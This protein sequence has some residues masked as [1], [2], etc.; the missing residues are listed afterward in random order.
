[1]ST[2]LQ[3]VCFFI[4]W[5]L[6]FDKITD[7]AGS[8]NFILVA[9]LSFFAAGLGTSDASAAAPRATILTA[10]VCVTRVELACFLLY[11]VLRRGKDDRFDAIRGNFFSF[12]FFWLFQ[13]V[14]AWGV[15]LPV[16]FVNADAAPE[17]ALGPRD[18]AGIAMWAA[19][20][21][22]QVVADLQKDA[23]RAQPANRGRACDVGVWSWCVRL[24]TLFYFVPVALCAFATVGLMLSVDIT[25]AR[26]YTNAS[27]S[28]HPNFFGEM[29]LWWGI[30]VAATPQLDA[31]S[32]RWGY[33]T[34]FSPV[35]TMLLLLF[36]SGMP[37]AEGDN[38]RR[39]LRTPEA[40]AAYRAYRERTSP[41]LPLP[42][43]LYAALPLVLKRWLLGEL[44]LYETDWAWTP[45]SEVPAVT[46][47]VGSA[48]PTD[49]L[50]TQPL[51]ASRVATASGRSS[52]G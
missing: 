7:L 3:L 46:I 1:M 18:A 10:L 2:V 21:L 30:F 43:P 40:A 12:L 17:P 16:I 37:T 41:L 48:A 25:S 5:T 36:A 11:R 23:F 22:L 20:F 44:S 39:F 49:S 34:I 52:R 29:L 33:V 14:W 15:S 27:R 38:Q 4:A 45:G 28:R 42:P 26:P 31:S 6:Q 35:L 32:S 51:R 24:S 47:A 50:V 9:L 8:A 13:I 19:G